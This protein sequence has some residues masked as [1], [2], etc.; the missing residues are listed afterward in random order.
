MVPFVPNAAMAGRATQ[1]QGY[2]RTNWS[3]DPLS[4]GSYSYVAKGAR[5][6]DR[7][8]LAE[9]M[10]GKV[11]FAGEAVH[12]RYNSTVHAAFESGQLAASSVLAGKAKRIAI[13]GAGMSGLSAAWFLAEAG[14]EVTVIEA[15]SRIGGRIWT[16]SRLGMPLDLGA[17]WIHGTSGNPLTALA[18]SLSL[19]RVETDGSYVLRGAD[20]REIPDNQAPDWLD[21]VEF[22][23]EAG[24]ER[25]KLNLRAYLLQTDYDGSEVVFPGGYAPIFKSLSA[26]YEVLLNRRVERI[27]MTS[28][29]VTLGIA[30]HEERAFDAVVVTLP[31][32]VLKQ[33]SVTFDP[34]LPK[35][36]QSAIDRLGMGVLDKL[37][38]KFDEVFWDEDVTW[39]STPET[40]L[41]QGQFNIWLNFQKYLGEPVLMAF[42]GGEAARALSG[43][44]DQALLDN[45]LR[46]LGEAYPD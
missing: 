11:F 2:L 29:G 20:G 24:T 10:G 43:Q 42:N 37:Y 23:T 7:K 19:T 46:V 34:P 9:P 28:D 26:G 8:R 36:K 6:R 16:D 5:Q 25:D 33:G 38:L 15:R 39:I 12:P 18:N 1:L 32:G 41:P 22:Q 4:F 3:R 27:G 30:D 40:G 31:L 14:R 17:S 13:I 45:A 21:E 44:T 35:D